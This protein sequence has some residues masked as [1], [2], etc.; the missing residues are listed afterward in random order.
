MLLMV[1]HPHS[2]SRLSAQETAC[3]L[4]P[5]LSD[6]LLSEKMWPF[7]EICFFR[8]LQLMVRA[9][10]PR[11]YMYEKEELILFFLPSWQ[12]FSCSLSTTGTTSTLSELV[13]LLS[14]WYIGTQQIL[15]ER[16]DYLTSICTYKWVF[17]FIRFRHM[18]GYLFLYNRFLEVK[19][20]GQRKCTF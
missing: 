15:V 13:S 20:K 9:T 8:K 17:L 11:V 14:V 6:L 3:S 2:H 4:T 7:M 16:I 19:L 10:P 1:H 18:N 5:L 12:S